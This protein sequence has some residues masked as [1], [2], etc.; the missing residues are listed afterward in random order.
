MSVQWSAEGKHEFVSK[1]EESHVGQ[2]KV[3]RK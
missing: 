2:Y 3:K 1:Q